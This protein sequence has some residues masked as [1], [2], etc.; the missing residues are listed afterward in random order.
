M[1]LD[2]SLGHFDGDDKALDA[3]EEG[4]EPTKAEARLVKVGND[5]THIQSRSIRIPVLLSP[6]ISLIGP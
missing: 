2:L 1:F 6:P 4:A 3:E 5:S